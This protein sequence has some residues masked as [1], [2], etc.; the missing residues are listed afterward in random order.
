M[1]NPEN[2]LNVCV[3]NFHAHAIRPVCF[4]LPLRLLWGNNIHTQSPHEIISRILRG[5]LK[6]VVLF[7]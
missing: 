4:F 6:T 1:Q 5:A 3:Y 7:F 2:M